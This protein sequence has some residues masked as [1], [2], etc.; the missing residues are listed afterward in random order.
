MGG[1]RKV[2]KLLISQLDRISANDRS[3]KEECLSRLIL[4][5]ENSLRRARTQ[6]IEHYHRERNHQGKANGLLFPLPRGP[7]RRRPQGAIPR[8]ERLV[9]LLKYY[10]RRAS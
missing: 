3:V 8:R 1:L 9:A 10:E 2:W 6:Y 5:G 7:A 4:I